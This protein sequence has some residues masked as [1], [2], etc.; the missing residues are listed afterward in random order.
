MKSWRATQ[1]SLL[2]FAT[3]KQAQQVEFLNG[4]SEE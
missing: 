2:K 1:I 4:K 3:Q